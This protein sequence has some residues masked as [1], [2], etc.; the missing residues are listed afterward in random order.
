MSGDNIQPP[1]NKEDAAKNAQ[2]SNS[3]PPATATP[4]NVAKEHPEEHSSNPNNETE[5]PKR[6]PLS[7]FEIWT[8][9]LGSIGI[10]V[11][12]GTAVAIYCQDKIASNTLVEIQ[13]QYPKLAKS[14]DAA[15]VS[16]TVAK[17]ALEVGERAFVSQTFTQNQEG[18]NVVIQVR[19]ANTGNTPT[20]GMVMHVS[21]GG[22]RSRPLPDKFSFP[23]IWQKG[24]SRVPTFVSIPAKDFGQGIYISIPR[25]L[26]PN[27]IGAPRNY[28]YV[29]GWARYHDMFPGTAEHIT[30]FCDEFT[31]SAVASTSVFVNALGM[32]ACG[33]H[34]CNDEG[35]NQDGQK[36]PN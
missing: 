13:K 26:L 6:K 2:R 7:R 5:K 27:K 22:L 12:S 36:N 31:T 15:N 9:V 35:C 23:D 34:N 20:K 10:L 21:F 18:N 33:R 11:A 29:W 25:T 4:V 16:A 14:A 28:F 8:I 32:S 19:W 1:D 24:E 3:E 17:S 30:E